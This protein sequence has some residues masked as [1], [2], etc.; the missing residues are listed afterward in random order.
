MHPDFT[1]MLPVAKR[2]WEALRARSL[3]RVPLL[4]LSLIIRVALGVA[5]FI[6]RAVVLVFLTLVALLLA[7][8]ATRLL[9]RLMARFPRVKRA[10]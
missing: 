2:L 1:D 6:T 3:A 4:L 7:S 9:Q 10:H 8:V 5:R